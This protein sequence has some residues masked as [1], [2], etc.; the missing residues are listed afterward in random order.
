MDFYQ[1][2][3]FL[4]IVDAGNFS[5]AAERVHVTQPTLSSGIKKLEDE[6]GVLLF[7]R[8]NRQVKLT[9]AGKQF[10]KRARVIFSEMEKAKE[11]LKIDQ[12]QATI[13]IGIFKTIP[14]E[15]IISLTNEFCRRHPTTIIELVEDTDEEVRA[16]LRMDQ[17]DFAVTTLRV[18]DKTGNSLLIF[19]EALFL[20]L[21]QNHP[22]ARRRTVSLR[23][24]DQ[25]PFIE[26]IN[27]ELWGE[28]QDEFK[29]CRI[30]P[31]SVYRAE[32]D[33]SVLSLIAS[34]LGLSIMPVRDNRYGIEFVPIEDLAIKRKIGIMW[35]DITRSMP[36]QQFCR[37]VKK[38]N[39]K[40][41]KDTKKR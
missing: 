41:T 18:E 24:V 40:D 23:E 33:S 8:T 32:T 22:L 19:E 39:H 15:P 2:K 29:R 6:L 11:E 12:G 1:I 26:R 25:Q 5:R 9:E 28:L 17:I 10:I 35:Q 31:Q 34:G 21:K 14:I 27:C 7:E 16:R 4:A 3:Y 13:R 38:V 37:F 20:A 30:Q 36:L